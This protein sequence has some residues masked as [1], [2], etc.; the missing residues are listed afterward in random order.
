V[1]EIAKSLSEVRPHC[2]VLLAVRRSQIRSV[3]SRLAGTAVSVVERSP[4]LDV[5]V[6]YRPYQMLYADEL[7]FVLSSGRR[8]LIGQLDM[9][10]FSNASYH[11]SEQLFFFARNLQRHLM[12][13]LDGVLFISRYGLA[14]AYS[15]CPDLD[16]DRLHVVSCGADPVALSGDITPARQR[17]LSDG[18]MVC[19]SSTFWHKNRTHAIA[20][21]ARMARDYGYR[22]SLVIAGPGP[23]FG[24]ST[25][26]EDAM[27]GS[28][29]ADVGARVLR[30]G[31]LDDQAKW[32]LLRHGDV[33]LYPSIVEGFG[34]VP[35]EAAVVGTPCLAHAGTAPGELLAGTSAVIESWDPDVW[36]TRAAKLAANEELTRALVGEVEAVAHRHTWR[37]CAERTWAA[38][39]HTV[40]APRRSIH[41]DD[42]RRLVRVGPQLAQRR[43]PGVRVRFDVAR[44]IPAVSRRITK[45]RMRLR[46]DS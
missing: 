34:L 37:A 31:H 2:E 12:R 16:V 7:P 10:G 40:A 24:R 41:A 21:F 39:D 5:D 46:G 19:L 6:V 18:F 42:G 14:S 38:I 13:T 33:V 28:L 22:G 26:A 36:A 11:P 1:V 17:D 15:E 23:Y 43:L 45:M 25:D 27:I 4:E 3:S 35:F 8:G 44:G 30:W 32:W 20:T 9:I 29:P